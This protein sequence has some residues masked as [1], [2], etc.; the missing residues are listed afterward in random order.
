MQDTN[1]NA[2]E[3]KIIF[4]ILDSAWVRLL[5]VVQ[6]KV[7]MTIVKNDNNKLIP[8]RMGLVVGFALNTRSRTK[9]LEKF[10]FHFRLLIM[11][12]SLVGY[13]HYFFLDGYS[14]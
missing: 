10:T 12:D 2:T 5:Q 7:G 3:G 4:A 6:K 1:A 13:S 14:R 11:L 8:T 9:Q